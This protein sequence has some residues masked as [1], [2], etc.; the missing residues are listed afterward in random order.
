MRFGFALLLLLLSTLAQAFP[1]KPMRIIVPYPPGGPSDHLARLIGHHLGERWGQKVIVENR[2]GASGIVGAAAGAKAPADGYT[3]IIAP[4][5]ILVVNPH[6][7]P[8][9]P[10]DALRDFAPVTQITTSPFL[11]AI[12]KSA[13]ARSLKELIGY[14]KA[15]PGKLTIGN[16]GVGTGQHLSVVHFAMTTG[17]DVT[18][19]SYKGSGPATTDLLGGVV[20]ALFDMQPLIPH[21]KA[22]KVQALAVTSRSRLSILPEVPTMGEATGQADYEFEAWQGLV[23][24]AGTPAPIIERV[25]QEIA[26]ILRVREIND[27]LVNQGLRPVGNTPAQFAAI[28]RSDLAR[29]KKL[30]ELGDV[31][32]Q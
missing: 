23:A 25:Q 4:V 29:Y 9:L 31:K 19:V 26:S 22:G 11:L 27:S 24:P 28:I 15:N 20:A 10:Y 8:S 18:H 14:A 12:S 2:A 17:I 32:P 13:P 7:Y 1:D 16:S 5:G 30:V 21:V 3:L 6:V